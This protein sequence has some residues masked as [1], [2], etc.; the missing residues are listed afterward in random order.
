MQIWQLGLKVFAEAQNVLARKQKKSKPQVLRWQ[1][2]LTLIFGQ[3][4]CR[5]APVF[6]KNGR[7]HPKKSNNIRKRYWQSDSEKNLQQ[8][9]SL[10]CEN[11][12]FTKLPKF[13]PICQKTSHT[14]QN[15]KYI[16][17]R[18]CFPTFSFGHI[19]YRYGNHDKCDKIFKNSMFWEKLTPFCSSRLADCGKQIWGPCR[20]VFLKNSDKFT[21]EF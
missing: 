13:F 8:L 1:K 10:S 5:Y 19:E 11:A 4:K 2:F 17:S 14:A 9:F 21:H 16:F 7:S 3:V 20:P 15:W 12:I 18:Q 6:K